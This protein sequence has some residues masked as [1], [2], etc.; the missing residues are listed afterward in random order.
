MAARPCEPRPP[1]SMIAAPLLACGRTLGAV[2]VSTYDGTTLGDG[3]LALVAHV[4]RRAGLA[5]GNTGLY[6][7]ARRT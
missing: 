2:T 5:L 1:T 3:E 6:N 7:R 4:A